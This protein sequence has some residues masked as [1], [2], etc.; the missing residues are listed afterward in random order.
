[1]NIHIKEKK[2]ILEKSEPKMN[3]I[4]YKPTTD[5]TQKKLPARNIPKTTFFPA[6][7][8]SFQSK[9]CENGE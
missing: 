1:V 2:V 3:T 4:S 5:H 9:L 6:S 8:R 7:L